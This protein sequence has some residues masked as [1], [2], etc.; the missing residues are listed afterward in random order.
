MKKLLFYL[1]LAYTFSNLLSCSKKGVKI[2]F[3][4]DLYLTNDKAC[5]IIENKTNKK[6]IFYPPSSIEDNDWSYYLGTKF[7]I[8]DEKGIEPKVSNLYLDNSIPDEKEMDKF[9]LN[10]KKDSLLWKDFLN[11]GI[12][13]NY[14]WVKSYKSMRK[15]KFILLPN[16][17]NKLL[18]K[19]TFFKSQLEKSGTYYTF[20]KNKKYFIHIEMEFDSTKIKEYLTPMDLD[21][22]RKNNISIFH[23]SLKTEEIPLIIE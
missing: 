11:R 23:G 3:C 18:K 13:V 21:S 10:E 12:K 9:L 19:I 8:T 6:Y 16:Q 14:N 22:L 2:R 5:F 20:D 4:N 15:N 17:E 7:I 1:F